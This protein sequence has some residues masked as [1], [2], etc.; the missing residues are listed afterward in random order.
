MLP[1][2]RLQAPWLGLSVAGGQK[3]GRSEPGPR[4]HTPEPTSSW[5]GASPAL[6]GPQWRSSR[7]QHAFGDRG[8][9]EVLAWSSGGPGLRDEGPRPSRDAGGDGACADRV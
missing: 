6:A 4:S 1:V 7:L 2:E 5:S 3:S 9:H 8:E